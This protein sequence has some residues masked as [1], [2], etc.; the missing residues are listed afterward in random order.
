MSQSVGV[1]VGA[2]VRVRDRRLHRLRRFLLEAFIMVP[3]CAEDFR[4]W[5]FLSHRSWHLNK[6]LC[7]LRNLRFHS[8]PADESTIV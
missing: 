7:N 3:L 1:G 4:T 2:S 6:N 5:V 8:L